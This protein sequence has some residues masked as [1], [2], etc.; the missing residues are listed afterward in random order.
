MIRNILLITIIPFYVFA[1]GDGSGDY[2]ILPRTVNF[3]L[4]VAILYYFI[5]TPIK[6]F[7]ND[8]INKISSKMNE[9][10]EKLIA[11][12]NLKLEMMKKLDLAKQESINAVA[13]AKKEAEILASKIENETKTELSVLE[14]SFQEHKKYEIRKM[15]K[16]VINSVLEE[17]FKDDNSYLKQEDII[18]IMMKK[19]S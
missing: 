18:N 7:Y 19:A 13:L 1:A 2:D 8:R 14:K 17:V 9:I 5:A 4:F 16:E 10:Q 6:K 3:I 15:E 11:S 12:K